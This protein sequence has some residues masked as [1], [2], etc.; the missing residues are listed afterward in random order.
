VTNWHVGTEITGPTLLGS[1]SLLRAG[2]AR[3]E[4]PFGTAD[5][6]VRES[7]WS[8]G[9]GLPIARQAAALDFSL[10]RA[11]RTSPG[12]TGRESAWLVG[13]GIKIRPTGL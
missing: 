1:A 2:F 6:L 9:V 5:R 13:F 3:S 11:F 12:S 8:A 7:R 4:L 10:Q